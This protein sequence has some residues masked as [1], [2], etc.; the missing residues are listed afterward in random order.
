M[1]FIR[2]TINTYNIYP[3]LK[4]CP[5]YNSDEHCAYTLMSGASHSSSSSL[6][7]YGLRGYYVQLAAAVSP[8]TRPA[9]PILGP[10]FTSNKHPA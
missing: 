2:H 4:F 1:D 6:I 5:S 8:G 9:K 3:Y 7:M 10:L